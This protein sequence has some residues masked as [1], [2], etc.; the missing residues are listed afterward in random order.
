VTLPVPVPG[1]VIRY[2]F[3]WVDEHA[4]GLE[5]G[6]KDR[7]CVVVISVLRDEN[8]TTVVVAPITHRPPGNIGDALEVPR[9]EEEPGPR[10]RRL[11]DRLEPVESLHLAGAGFAPC[12]S[13]GAQALQLW[14]SAERLLSW[15]RDR[16]DAIATSRRISIVPRTD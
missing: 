9:R 6:R 13:L 4:A 12:A 11:V 1:L 3:L 2:G 14:L 5:H 16:V 10:S 15:L 7:P 8:E